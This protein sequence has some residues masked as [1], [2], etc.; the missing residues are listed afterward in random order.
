MD[1]VQ[2]NY[3]EES[4]RVCIIDLKVNFYFLSF[5]VLLWYCANLDLNYEILS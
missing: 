4:F 1:E 3:D 2:A 5:N